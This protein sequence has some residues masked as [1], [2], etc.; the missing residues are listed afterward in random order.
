M[1]T[2]QPK[3]TLSTLMAKANP[4]SPHMVEFQASRNSAPQSQHCTQPH[5]TSK[6]DSGLIQQTKSRVYGALCNQ[7]WIHLGILGYATIPSGA[8]A[9]S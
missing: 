8:F 9:A 6:I 7:K 5:L 1:I 3:T 2:T 4:K